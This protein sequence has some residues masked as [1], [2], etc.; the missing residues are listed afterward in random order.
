M[1]FVI[2]SQ[3][4]QAVSLFYATVLVSL[5]DLS[6]LFIFIIITLN[7]DVLLT[8]IFTYPNKAY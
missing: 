1:F 7:S 5:N 8:K 6:I 4:N 2:K 3:S